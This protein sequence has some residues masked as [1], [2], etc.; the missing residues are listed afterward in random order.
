MKRKERVETSVWGIGRGYQCFAASWQV[1][2]QP[3]ATRSGRLH[4]ALLRAAAGLRAAADSCNAQ[5][6][7]ARGEGERVRAGLCCC[8]PAGWQAGER[9]SARARERASVCVCVCCVTCCCCWRARSC[10]ICSWLCC[11]CSSGQEAGKEGGG[12]RG[13][14]GGRDRGRRD[15]CKTKKPAVSAAAAAATHRYTH[16]DTHTDIHTQRYTLTDTHPHTI[17]SVIQTQTQ[18]QTQKQTQTQTQTQT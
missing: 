14:G 18:T 17:D 16:T 10:W 13:G 12:R 5:P 3:R 2:P 8:R 9:E 11:C 15:V 7:C 4:S 6:R 1:R